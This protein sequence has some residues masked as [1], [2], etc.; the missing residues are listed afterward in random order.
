MQ[1]L[2]EWMNLQMIFRFEGNHEM[3]FD[4]S[5]QKHGKNRPN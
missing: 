1:S 5:W 4:T 2:N 3:V